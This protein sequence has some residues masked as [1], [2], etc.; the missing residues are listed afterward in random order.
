MARILGLESTCD[1]TAAAVVADG[2]TVLSN[3]VA[4][5]A[6][7]HA[8]Y[9]GVVPEIASRAHIENI[10]PVIRESL[11][12]SSTKLQD[13]DAISV[14]HRPGLIGSLLIGVTAAKTLAWSLRKPL[15]G[16][17]HV[18]AHLYS[19][20][21]SSP[22]LSPS[23]GTPG[24]G[25]G[26]G[27]S[28]EVERWKLEVGRSPLVANA[29]PSILSDPLPT[30]IFPALGLVISGGHTAL[31]ELNSFT[32]L[33]LIGATID[34]AV[35]EAYDKVSAILG[36]GYP[37]GPIID[38]L[39]ISGDPN[40]IKFPRTLLARD[41]LDFSFSGLK[42]AVLY[43]VRG[44]PTKGQQIKHTQVSLTD[45][46][47]A[48]ISASFQS[49]CIDVITTKLKRAAKRTKAKSILIGGGVS[50]NRGLRQALLSFSLPVLFPPLPYCTDNAAM[51][52]ALA[53]LFHERSDF[54][55]LSLD[56]I[57]R[58]QFSR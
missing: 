27:S 29:S 6:H 44:V 25:R 16:V 17:D 56:A 12:Q 2:R 10:L 35:G 4:S 14:A 34:D 31:Y 53:H 54:S 45:R 26:E 30:P 46:D 18:H 43:H 47:L 7:L 36:L 40:A 28:L 20:M 19:V 52:A 24:E 8:K 32:D 42:T 41:S 21:L 55:P 48:N 49:A 51:S 15:I 5:Q 9:R 58:S 23:P 13:I 37:G 33:H 22:A 57:P 38:N 1:E 11:Q 39:A 50:A 3:V